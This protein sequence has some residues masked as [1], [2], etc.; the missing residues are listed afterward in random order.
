MSTG[1]SGAGVSSPDQG[2][3]SPP[4]STAK[5][6]I[7]EID[8]VNQLIGDADTAR[9]H[10][11][12]VYGARVAEIYRQRTGPYDNFLF[13]LGT[14][15]VEV[16]SP[17]D[18]EHS[19]GRQHSRFG[20]CWQGCLLRVPD[21]R[22]AIDVCSERRIPVVD[23]NLERGWAFTDPRTTYFSIQ[24]EDRDDWDKSPSENDAGVERLHGFSVAVHDLE[25]AVAFFRETIAGADVVYEEERAQIGGRAAGVR[26][27][28]YVVELQSPVTDG[29][30]AAFLARYRE[31]VRT[32]TWKVESLD[33]LARHLAGCDVAVE[34]GDRAGTLAVRSADN[35]D[36]GMQFVE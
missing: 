1:P 33:G 2:D 12:R 34:P 17:V 9:E 35:L 14:M 10:Y 6:E 31:R 19:F 28:G 11:E 22:E 23:V 27:A 32:M 7:L 4:A 8:H 13:K 29:D 20:N 15:T 26:I 30:L 5:L 24:L 36:V 3:A 16:F 21:L 25:A 18:R